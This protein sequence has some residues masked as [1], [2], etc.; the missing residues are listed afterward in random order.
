MK[1]YMCILSIHSK[2]IS[3]VIF[4]KIKSFLEVDTAYMQQAEADKLFCDSLLH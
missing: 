4:N 2:P 1:K 3:E